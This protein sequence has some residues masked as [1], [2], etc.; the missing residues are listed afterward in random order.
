MKEN[1]LRRQPMEVHAAM[2]AGMITLASL[3]TPSNSSSFSV[4]VYHGIDRL[5]PLSR[6]EEPITFVY[7]IT[8]VSGWG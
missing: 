7:Y 5:L 8:F 2:T 6:R 4:C 3:Y 1:W